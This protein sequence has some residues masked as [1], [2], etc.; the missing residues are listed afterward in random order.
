MPVRFAVPATGC[1][2][3]IVATLAL[4]ACEAQP[5]EE[6]LAD[7][8]TVSDTV[9]RR[10]ARVTRSASA[11]QRVTGAIDAALASRPLDSTLAV[12]VMDQRGRDLA[13]VSV[14]WTVHNPADG[15]M[16]RVID[17]RTDSLGVS[18][19]E[20]TPGRTAMSQTV[21]AEARGVGRIIFAVSVPVASI[22]IIVESSALWSGEDASVSTELHDPAGVRLSDGALGWGTT[23]STILAMVSSDASRAR[24]RGRLAGAAS[25]VAWAEPGKVRDSALM[26]VK[27][28]VSGAFVTI[29]GSQVPPM[30][31]RIRAGAVEDSIPVANARYAKRVQ[32]PFYSG[33]ELLAMPEGVHPSHAV[34]I[35]MT[36]PRALQSMTIALVPT[37]WRIDAGTFAGQSI[38]IDATRALRRASGSGGFWRLTPV[39]GPGPVALIG[40]PEEAWP[41]RIAFNHQRAREPI[42]PEDS[43]EFWKIAEQ[44]HRDLGMR[45]FVPA[46][47]AGDTVPPGIIPVD[48]GTDAGEGHTFVTFDA[49]GDVYDG[50]LMFR[51]AATLRNSHVVTHELLHLLGFGHA[52]SFRSVAQAVSGTEPRLTP[53]DVAYT[54]VAMRLRRL[55]RNAGAR[56]G[57][58]PAP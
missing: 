40:W 2:I 12:R 48:I 28:L 27:P 14:S 11:I 55:Q 24:V 5:R 20:F 23:D 53:E 52:T 18:R 43:V 7:T 13:G 56:P 42:T 36:S 51:R 54:Q 6:A 22:R 3:A 50:V 57:L 47:L 9:V 4:A 30:R 8:A 45:V 25:I 49:A 26:V 31:L 38:D 34:Q 19:A 37:T 41:L 10:V 16:L 33:V 46:Q 35:R 1:H 15:S 21:V 39:T 32:L 58:P 44:M 29:D 17:A